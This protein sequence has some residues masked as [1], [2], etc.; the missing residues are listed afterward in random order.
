MRRLL[1]LLLAV[2][3][4]AA[5]AKASEPQR[6]QAAATPADRHRLARLWEA[7]TRSLA[8]VQT[9]GQGG[10]L[11]ALGGAVIPDAAA[12][13]ADP[14]DRAT[15]ASKGPLPIPGNYQCRTIHLGQKDFP[16]P[17]GVVQATEPVPCTI[18]QRGATLWFESDGARR[19]IGRLYADGDRL[20]LLGTTSLAGEMGTV[21]YGADP[22]RDAI[23]ALRALAPG[24]WRLELP[25]PHWQSTLDV[26]EMTAG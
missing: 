8:Q 21:A 26:I 16:A 6:W 7:W 12:L 18:E 13:N 20:V 3:L 1:P 15:V 2:A 9:A 4:M 25:W 24:K 10:A 11:A 17:A 19:L 23:G 14:A 22:D 5:P